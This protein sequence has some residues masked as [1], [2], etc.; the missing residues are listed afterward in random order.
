MLLVDTGPLVAAADPK[1]HWHELCAELL[2]TETHPLVVPELVL[3]EVAQLVAARVGPQAEVGIAQA[4]ALGEI[5]PVPT[6]REDWHRIGALAA[7]YSDL[8]L[9]LVDAAVIAIAERLHVTRL[10]TLDRR[11]LTVV[12]PAHV[13]AFE[14]VP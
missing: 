6:E 14:L 1:D 5:R 7:K 8:P 10:A 4:V 12:R 2:E 13:D 11:H 3:T 9:G